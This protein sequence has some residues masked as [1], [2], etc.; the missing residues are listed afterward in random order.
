LRL[1]RDRDGEKNPI[2]SLIVREMPD[3]RMSTKFARARTAALAVVLAVLVCYYANS[4]SERMKGGPTIESL[5]GPWQ[6]TTDIEICA[7][8]RVARIEPPPEWAAR[9]IANGRLPLSDANYWLC[10]GEEA[11]DQLLAGREEARRNYQARV[12]RQSERRVD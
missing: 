8:D 9:I 1:L 7:W 6:P 3:D 10:N 12:R 5:T 4:W 2:L 11:H